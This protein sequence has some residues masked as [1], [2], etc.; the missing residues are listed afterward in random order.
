MD[1]IIGFVVGFAFTQIAFWLSGYMDG[2]RNFR[3]MEQRHKEMRDQIKGDI[4]EV[5]GRMS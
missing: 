3:E 4:D 5:R 2:Q 1:F